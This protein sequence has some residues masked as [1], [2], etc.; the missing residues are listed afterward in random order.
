MI[1]YADVLS[2]WPG[3]LTD[4]YLFRI[5]T[6]VVFGFAFLAL[7][8][9]TCF[10]CCDIIEVLGLSEVSVCALSTAI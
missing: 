7:S 9:C 5:I 8:S 2:I 10:G 1:F 4:T 6:A 3:L